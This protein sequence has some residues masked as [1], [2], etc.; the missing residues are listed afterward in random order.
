MSA[1]LPEVTA[2]PFE[3]DGVLGRALECGSGG[4]VVVCLHGTGSRADRFRHNLPGLAAAGFHIYAIDCPGHGF[5][6]KGRNYRYDEPAFAEFVTGFLDQVTP[7]GAALLGTSMGAHLATMVAA[8]RPELVSAVLFVGG[9][10]LV[11]TRH[12][13]RAKSPDT[14]DGSPTGIRRKLEFLVHDPTLVTDVWVY[15][16][17]RINGSPGARLA[18]A[19]LGRYS[20]EEDLVGARYRDQNIPTLLVWGAQDQ[21]VPLAWAYAVRELLPAAPLVLIDRTGHAPYFERPQAFNQV[22]IDFLRDPRGAAPTE[23]TV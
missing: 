13:P 9:V 5:A 4:D 14:A 8:D 1:A 2:W 21:W 23:R 11:S 19:E 18:L 12:L 20:H 17:G 15:E 6:Y 3:V 16:E 22:A 7:Q 10:G